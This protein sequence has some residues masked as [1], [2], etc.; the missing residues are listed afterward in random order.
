[1]IRIGTGVDTVSL[2]PGFVDSELS[3][4]AKGCCS[5]SGKLCIENGC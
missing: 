2:H 4:E 1:M 5:L 3:R